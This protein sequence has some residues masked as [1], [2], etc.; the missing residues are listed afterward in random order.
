MQQS[1][2]HLQPNYTTIA[3]NCNLWRNYND[4]SDS[5]ESLLGIITHY[6]EQQ[7]QFQPFAGPGQWNDPDMVRTLL[8]VMTIW[9]CVANK[10]TKYICHV[11]P[12]TM[13]L[14][15]TDYIGKKNL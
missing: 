4:I 11:F 3:E 7:D 6:G 2:I 14:R 13:Y 5:W 9:G 1:I 10:I 12:E 15:C 8:F